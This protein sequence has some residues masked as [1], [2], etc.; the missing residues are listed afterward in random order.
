MRST[1]HLVLAALVALSACSSSPKRGDAVIESTEIKADSADAQKRYEAGLTLLREGQWASA[2]EEFR[3]LQSEFPSDAIAQ[4]AELYAARA[5]LRDLETADAGPQR[6]LP[7]LSGLARSEDIDT[8]VRY[9]AQIYLAAAHAALNDRSAAMAAL[10]AYP[11]AS[12]SPNVLKRDRAAAWTFVV[13]ALAEQNRHAEAVAA[14]AETYR[15]GAETPQMRRYAQARGFEL[16]AR[17]DQDILL[18]WSTDEFVFLRAI[19]GYELSRQLRENAPEDVIDRAIAALTTVGDDARAQ[20]IS[21]Y[22]PAQVAKA[23]RVGVLLPLSGPNKAMGERALQGAMLATLTTPRG[24][25]TLVVEDSEIQGAFERLQNREVLAV[26]GPLD[27]SRTR[28]VAPQAADSAIPILALSTEIPST[29][30]PWVFQDFVDADYEADAAAWLASQV[31]ATRVAIVA[32]NIGYGQRMANRF[33]QAAEAAGMTVVLNTSYDRKA[34]DY[35]KVASAVAAAK[36]DAVYIPDTGAK[37]AEV[38]AF[39]AAKNIWGRVHGTPVPRDGRTRVYYLGTSLW[40]DDNLVRQAGSYIEG[41]LIPAWYSPVFTSAS[42]RQFFDRWVAAGHTTRPAELEVFGYDAVT[43]LVSELQ[44]IPQMNGQ[45]LKTA[46]LDSDPS[47]GISAATWGLDGRARRKLGFI[48]VSTAFTA[49]PW[50]YV[51]PLVDRKPAS[52]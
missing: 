10:N 33:R 21:L 24:E 41:A 29:T 17:V 12:L 18:E 50:E 8:R 7:L 46:L 6:A 20:E 5:A 37:V 11:G 42:S 32:P 40:Q 27:P 31:Q 44:R 52:P 13:E 35:S 39:L 15:E 43:H 1:M 36:P 49:T 19:G 28:E 2:E 23:L 47:I 34:T 30:D 38:T 45:G 9:A 3:L 51:P 4:V 26:V 25:V 22:R 48:S 16:A 14:C